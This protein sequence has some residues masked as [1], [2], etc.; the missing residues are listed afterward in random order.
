MAHHFDCVVDTKPMARSID[1]VKKN[2]EGTTGAVVAMKLAVVAAEKEGAD[3]VCNKV[4][5]GFYSLIHSQISQKMAK[6]QSEVDAKLMRLNQQKKQLLGIRKRMERDYQMIC[7]RYIKTFTSINR[8]LKQRIT[9]ID[10]PVMDLVQTDAE[11]ITNRSSQLVATV[12]L[13]QNESVKVSQRLATSNLKNRALGTIESIHRFIDASNHLNRVTNSIL[14]PRRIEESTEEVMIPVAVM[15]S[16]YDGSGNTVQ[17]AIVSEIPL[18][19]E[20]T[21]AIE[22]GISFASSNNQL[23]WHKETR[24]APETVNNFRRMVSESGL[25]K[26]RQDMMLKMLESNPFDVLSDK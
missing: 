25:D 24:I 26:R 6:L 22:N 19:K 8:N 7:A 21:S 5:K 9:E 16:N 3:H 18:S 11:K 2:V 23:P 15:E 4:N 1:S 13:S 17:K 14:L 20:F 10:R 12:P